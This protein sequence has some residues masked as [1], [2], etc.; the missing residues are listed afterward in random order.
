MPKPN[1]RCGN[2]CARL[3]AARPDAGPRRLSG[4]RLRTIQ[5]FLH[6]GFS[7]ARLW[8]G[9]GG[10][11]STRATLRQRA[12]ASTTSRI[13]GSAAKAAYSDRSTSRSLRQTAPPS[14]ASIA[15][16]SR[17]A[18]RITARRDCGPATIPTITPPSCSIRTG[19][20]SRR[21]VTHRSDRASALQPRQARQFERI[22]LHGH[23]QE[24]MGPARSGRSDDR[25]RDE[26]IQKRQRGN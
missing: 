9:D 7:A 19:I 12:L 8:S 13:F 6:T 1:W 24:P 23:C 21:C 17:P 16:R 20:T 15:K 18:A 26:A 2:C 14:T 22:S 25:L 5:G 11:A 4:F 10:S 3:S